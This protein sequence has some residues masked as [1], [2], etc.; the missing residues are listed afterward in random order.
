M[1]APLDHV[2][3]SRLETLLH[4]GIWLP[5]ISLPFWHA[6]QISNRYLQE[7]HP[8]FFENNKTIFL[9]RLKDISDGEWTFWRQFFSFYICVCLVSSFV[10][11]LT[12][13][14]SLM[15]RKI[16][17]ITVSFISISMILGVK[18]FLLILAFSCLAYVIAQTKVVPLIW[19]FMLSA[20]YVI[21]FEPYQ[22]NIVSLVAEDDTAQSLFIFSIMMG[23]LRLLSFA[24][25]NAKVSYAEADSPNIIDFLAYVFYFPLFLNGP[26]LTFDTFHN[27][28]KQRVEKPIFYSLVL[29]VLSCIVYFA[30]VEVSYHFF[31]SAS[32]S[33]HTH[34][35][36]ELS[37]WETLGIIWTQLQF[38]YVK[39]VVFYRF[40]GIFVKIDGMEP[41]GQP[42]CISN[43]YTFVDMW[44]YFDKGLNIFL[45]RYIYIPMGGSQHGM[46]RQIIASF[47]SFAFVGYWHGGTERYLVWAFTNW[48]GISL[49]AFTSR[50]LKLQKAQ[51]ITARIGPKMYRRICAMFGS[52][53]V[54]CL[55]LSNMVFLTGT[56]ATLVYIN[57]LFIHG[58]PVGPV[59][60]FIGMYCAV[61]CIIDARLP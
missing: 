2:R 12:S 32:I 19:A 42:G 53:T 4:W 41:P 17:L 54:I 55:I 56:E 48:V 11:N 1:A 61:N 27:Q 21:N 13:S 20:T 36:E 6:Y 30:L 51:E 37:C 9:D 26:I 23:N 47:M 43:L 44:R 40:A 8:A 58:S 60:V 15:A 49:E 59:G 28:M 33:K 50:L 10:C 25:D 18:G 3:A 52:V 38:F 57:R 35:L 5:C 29:D 22:M 16:S 14:I 31:Y 7:L 24:L 46:L 39:Y 45:R 34:I